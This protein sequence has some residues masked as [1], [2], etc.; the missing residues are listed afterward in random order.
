MKARLI[1][2]LTAVA[3]V[4][5]VS[6]WAL[7]SP[8]PMS[9]AA[10]R[11]PKL[12]THPTL[13]TS[14]RATMAAPQLSGMRVVFNQ[15]FSGH[16]LNTSVWG[17]CYPWLEQ[18]AGCTNFGNPEEK[19]W[20]L[21]SQDRVIGGALH[22]IAQR[23]RTEGTT[24]SGAPKVYS[25]RS[26]MVTTYPSFQFKYGY[27]QISA[28]IPGNAGLWSGLWLAAANFKWPPEVD[29][30]ERWGPPASV[31]GV[32]LHPSQGPTDRTHLTPA[33]AAGLSTGWHTFAIRWTAGQITWYVD[34]KTIM[35]ARKD[36]PHQQMYIIFNLADVSSRTPGCS[37]QLL[38][39]SVKV[40][41]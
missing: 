40:W 12:V 30:L 2:A 19:E 10:T 5:G 33:V 1:L 6:A 14:P 27:V 11:P 31:A 7:V 22:L 20:Y 9:R 34:G 18:P 26:G 28:R 39:R 17:T 37:G 23:V 15:H 21:P 4:I 36:I 41:Q 3:A 24:S 16:S 38:V 35:V 32:Y 25:C 8:K 13:S 29:I